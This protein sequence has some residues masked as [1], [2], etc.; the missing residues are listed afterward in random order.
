MSLENTL[1][2]MLSEQNRPGPGIGAFGQTPIRNP[3]KEVD[4]STGKPY[5]RSPKKP[6]STSIPSPAPIVNRPPDNPKPPTDPNIQTHNQEGLKEFYKARLAGALLGEASANRLARLT[7]A[8]NKAEAKL[9]PADR[10]R[11]ERRRS[12]EAGKQGNLGQRVRSGVLGAVEKI[13]GALGGGPSAAVKRVEALRGAEAVAS[14]AV[15]RGGT[16]S[17][18][19]DARIVTGARGREAARVSDAL[20]RP[21]E[22]PG[23]IRPDQPHETEFKSVIGNRG[24]LDRGA[25]ERANLGKRISALGQA[26]GDRSLAGT[27]R[28]PTSQGA[29]GGYR[30]MDPG[31]TTINT[32]GSV[33]RHLDRGGRH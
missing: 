6:S 7:R 4:L 27:N 19:G 1:R 25:E 12:I 29:Q 9:S 13:R 8:G 18:V 2:E 31:S 30:I 28:R 11:L 26:G 32:A 14:A 3:P 21:S 15:S 23:R 22:R 5:V 17:R 20:A 10:A 33:L 16:M 24:P